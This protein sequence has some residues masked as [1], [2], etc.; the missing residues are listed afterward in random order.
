MSRRES[1]F[2]IISYLYFFFLGKNYLILRI[3]WWYG[4]DGNIGESDY[5]ILEFVRERVG[6]VAVE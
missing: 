6:N 3:D 5:I 1:L 4:S 2:F